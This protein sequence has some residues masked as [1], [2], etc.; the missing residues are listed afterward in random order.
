MRRRISLQNI[1][2]FSSSFLLV[3]ILAVYV[4][5]RINRLVVRLQNSVAASL[6]RNF[7][8][9]IS[10]DRVYFTGFNSIE[11]RG[12]RIHRS[13]FHDRAPLVEIRKLKVKLNFLDLMFSSTK[14]DEESLRVLEASGVVVNYYPEKKLP[15]GVRLSGKVQEKPK[16][17]SSKLEMKLIMDILLLDGWVRVYS[18]PYDP[19]KPQTPLAQLQIQQGSFRMNRG[20]ARID[21]KSRTGLVSRGFFSTRLDVSGDIGLDFRQGDLLFSLHDSILGGAAIHDFRFFASLRKGVFSVDSTPFRQALHLTGSCSPD[22]EGLFRLRFTRDTGFFVAFLKRYFPGGMNTSFFLPGVKYAPDGQ[23]TA[24]IRKGKVRLDGGIRIKNPRGRNVFDLA[25]R[26]NSRILSV[27]RFRMEQF[28]R[29]IALRGVWRFA[30]PLPEIQGVLRSVA[31]GENRV[32]GTVRMRQYASG[33]YRL[34]LGGMV[35]NGAP[36]GR[37]SSLVSM[38][39]SGIELNTGG[40]PQRIHVKGRISDEKNF[41]LKLGLGGYSFAVLARALRTTPFWPDR[42]A[43]GQVNVLMEDGYLSSSGNVHA[44]HVKSASDRISVS[45]SYKGDRLVLHNASMPGYGL[46]LAGVV[47]ILGDGFRMRM[48]GNH[49]GFRFGV[50]GGIKKRGADYRVNVNIPGYLSAGGVLSDNGLFCR[51][52]MKGVPLRSMGVDLKAGGKGSVSLRRGVVYSDGEVR[53]EGPMLADA[54]L[55]SLSVEYSLRDMDFKLRKIA[56]DAG[57][58]KLQGYGHLSFFGWGV[59]GSLSIGKSLEAY[60]NY[61]SGWFDSK[62]VLK[63]YQVS[64]LLGDDFSGELSGTVLATGRPSAPRVACNLSLKKGR[65]LGKTLEGTIRSSQI[66]GGIRIDGG[67]FSFGDIRLH[68]G[69]G[70]LRR[71]GSG[72]LVDQKISASLKSSVAS[73]KSSLH[74]SGR[75]ENGSIDVMLGVGGF[76]INGYSFG[77]MRT[78]MLYARGRVNLFRRSATGLAG[79]LDIRQNAFSLELFADNRPNLKAEGVLQGRE[80]NLFLSSD[81]FSL[82]AL[83]LL[84]GI[85]KDAGGL[86]K[87]QL[88]VQG[89]VDDVSVKGLFRVT[90]GSFLSPLLQKRVKQV[91]MNILFN[92]KKVEIRR[93]SGKCGD[94]SFLLNGYCYLRKN[95]LED[96]NFRFATGRDKGLPVTLDI[97]GFKLKGKVFADLFLRGD[98]DGPDLQGRVAVRDADIQYMGGSS[99]S[100]SGSGSGSSESV[101]DRIRWHVDFTVLDGVNYLNPLVTAVIKPQSRI[102]FRNRMADSNFRIQGKLDVSH[103]SLDYVSHQFKLEDPT[104]LEFKRAGSGYDAWLVFKGKTTVKDDNQE[105]I[106]IYISFTGSLSGEIKPTF[107]SEP[108]KTDQEI[109]KLLGIQISSTDTV[110]DGKSG[111]FLYKSTDLISSIGFLQPLSKEIRQRIGLDMLTI[112]TS[113]VR[114]LLERESLDSMDPKRQLSIWRDTQFTL[115]KYLTS[116]LFLEYTL[117]L[118]ESTKTPGDLVSA[119]KVGV[120]LSFSPFNLGYSLK[121]TQKSGY[122]DY[123]QSFEIRFRKRF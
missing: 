106:N 78:Q 23:L 92:G 38:D 45:Y 51:Y 19:H 75:I 31:L 107:Y 84:P 99:G 9:R 7:N 94:G 55:K 12:L 66:A 60:L 123:E 2:L 52:S 82:A 105:S 29:M 112:R 18:S 24:K 111:N 15:D 104:Y 83:K 28:P 22:G 110:D 34:S 30:D 36:L 11:V 14:E 8:I 115:G 114:Y 85:F 50:Y 57:K 33:R 120:E 73:L 54:G 98:P 88:H 53:V 103:G 86:G 95:N 41:N 49:R 26:A 87:F 65:L 58:I 108:S 35:V 80:V 16:G 90:A 17:P 42:I 25:F 119:H 6:E 4:N 1:I 71:S 63:K 13:A 102:G 89:P 32:S 74:A 96:L 27:D 113:V 79:F 40:I 39:E 3:F 70:M 101:A 61:E 37:F 59:R 76:A 91:A 117:M 5:F 121:Q 56:L 93:F 72:Y 77:K 44:Q 68:L 64:G 62:V 100:G 43:S 109:K 67:D 69:R 122:S 10:H 118:K 116:F 97:S 46:R 20:R 48:N 47:D 21:L 81:H